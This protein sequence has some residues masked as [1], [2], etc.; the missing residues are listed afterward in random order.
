M[1]LASAQPKPIIFCVY[2]GFVCGVCASS[3]A[4]ACLL[5]CNCTFVFVSL[6]LP[7]LPVCL[8]LCRKA[9]GCLSLCSLFASLPSP[10][11]LYVTTHRYANL[12]I[13]NQSSSSSAPFSHS[14]F[15][16]LFSSLILCHTFVCHVSPPLPFSISPCLPASLFLLP[17]KSFA[18]PYSGGGSH[19]STPCPLTPNRCFLFNMFRFIEFNYF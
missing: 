19:C 2:E 4:C 15:Y 1:K 18:L 11:P 7:R 13:F 8:Q 9:W 10:S 5:Q 12:M 16:S 17:C 3:H 6:C 14:S